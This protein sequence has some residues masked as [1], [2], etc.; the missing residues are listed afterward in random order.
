[1]IGDRSHSQLKDWNRLGRG[2]PSTQGIQDQEAKRVC[3][4]IAQAIDYLMQKVQDIRVPDESL[5]RTDVSARPG[6]K[7]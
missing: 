7:T 4:A 3:D 1:M 5:P 6:V 2:M